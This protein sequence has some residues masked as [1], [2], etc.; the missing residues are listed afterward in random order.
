MAT[1]NHPWAEA[2]NNFGLP[3]PLPTIY[4]MDLI[5]MQDNTTKEMSPHILINIATPAGCTT[6]FLDEVDFL[7]FMAQGKEIL[8]DLSKS[9]HPSNLHIQ[10]ASQT[11]L[12]NEIRGQ[13]LLNKNTNPN[14]K[15]S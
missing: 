7:E 13:Y 12:R 9:H 8:K 11:D 1:I 6:V 3:M 4:K 14:G 15:I 10:P 5:Q 2:A